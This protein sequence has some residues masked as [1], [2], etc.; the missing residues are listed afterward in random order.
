MSFE[1]T[2]GLTTVHWRAIHSDYFK[3]K[4]YNIQKYESE[5]RYYYFMIMKFQ[6]S[7]FTSNSLFTQSSIACKDEQLEN[8]RTGVSAGTGK[9]C[10]F[11]HLELVFIWSCF[12]FCLRNLQKESRFV[13][14]ILLTT[15]MQVLRFEEMIIKIS[16]K[17]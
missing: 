7:A 13:T 6:F 11:G 2:F 8:Q 9:H 4:R 3:H 12:V 14:L 16:R 1:M 15:C 17:P 10:V 5:K